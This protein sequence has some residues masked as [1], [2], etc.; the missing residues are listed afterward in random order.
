MS[1]KT[2]MKARWQGWFGKL[3]R[4]SVTMTVEKAIEN[5]LDDK[6]D[7]DVFRLPPRPQSGKRRKP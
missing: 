7:K 3:I 4:D 5:E 1:F 6:D 2:W